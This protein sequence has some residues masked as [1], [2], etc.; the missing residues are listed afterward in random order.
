MSIYIGTTNK[1]IVNV[2]KW[3]E[4]KQ[5]IIFENTG[6]IFYDV[7]YLIDFLLF[8]WIRNL[9]FGALLLRE[10]GIF[11]LFKMID[12]LSYERIRRLLVCAFLDH[13]SIN[14][15]YNLKYYAY[16]NNSIMNATSWLSDYCICVHNE[17]TND[18]AT[19]H[20]YAFIYL[21]TL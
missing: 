9:K 6:S 12:I 19:K 1:V 15:R 17:K 21:Y 3:K 16:K 18:Q 4:E 13:D 2:H 11:V 7:F 5:I 20:L 14:S 8:I 10:I